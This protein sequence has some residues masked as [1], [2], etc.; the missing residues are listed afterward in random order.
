MRRRGREG[1]AVNLRRG[2]RQLLPPPTPKA[3][4]PVLVRMLFRPYRRREE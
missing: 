4:V 3:L 1:E 2:E